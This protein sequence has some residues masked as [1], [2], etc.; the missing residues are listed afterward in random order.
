MWCYE[1]LLLSPCGTAAGGAAEASLVGNDR[2]GALLSSAKIRSPVQA[3]EVVYS[4][5]LRSTMRR[6]N[7]VRISICFVL[8]FKMLIVFQSVS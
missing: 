6:D 5:V 1:I 8:S 4:R 3:C 7:G 2:Q